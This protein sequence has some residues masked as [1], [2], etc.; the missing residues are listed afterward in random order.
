MF[1]QV[2]KN[3]GGLRIVGDFFVGRFALGTPKG[4]DAAVLAFL[5]SFVKDARSS[6]L[7]EQA[8]AATG[9]QDLDLPP[10]G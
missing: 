4:A 9:K 6:G 10:T 2:L 8:I 5:E 3:V 7:I 1:D